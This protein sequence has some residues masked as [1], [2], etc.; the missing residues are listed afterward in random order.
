MHSSSSLLPK[1]KL[2]SILISLSGIINNLSVCFSTSISTVSLS[3]YNYYFTFSISLSE[4]I[5]WKKEGIGNGRS[6]KKKTIFF[7][8]LFCLICIWL[9]CKLCVLCGYCGG[10]WGEG[11]SFILLCG[12]FGWYSCIAWYTE[13]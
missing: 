7:T 11:L 6:I 1:R 9:L 8:I 10:T 13:D 2:P 5:F 3:A 4:L 12:W